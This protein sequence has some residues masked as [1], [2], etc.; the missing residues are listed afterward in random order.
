M[1]PFN[2]HLPL[3]M[4][5]VVSMIAY[6]SLFP[7]A[8]HTRSDSVGPFMT[9]LGGWDKLPGRGDFVSNILLYLP[10][11]FVGAMAPAGRASLRRLALAA[12]FGAALSVGAE[13]L[14]Y[15]DAYRDTEATDVYANTLGTMLGATAGWLFGREFR[16]PFL[17]ELSANRIPA[18]L[19]AAWLGYRLY[20]YVPTINLHK[21]WD[22]LK[23]IVL[24]PELTVLG[25]LRQTAIWLCIRALSDAIAGRRGARFYWLFAGATF[26][27]SILILFTWITAAQIAGIALAFVSWRMMGRRR[28]AVAAGLLGAYIVLYRLEPFRFDPYA[29]H[30]SWLP[31]LSFMQGSINTD[32]QA[33]CEKFFLYGGLIW[34]LGRA[35]VGIRLATLSTAMLLLATSGLEAIIPG[36]SAEVTDALLALAA[37]WIV[38][39]E[40]PKLEPA[41]EPEK[42]TVTGQFLPVEPLAEPVP[43]YE[44]AAE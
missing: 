20:P 16:M 26:V 22:A 40:R 25:L 38:G 29:E 43:A 35:G 1:K 4:V 19:L 5:A 15:Y 7:F 13:C 17:R 6:G 12:A 31:F 42:V 41:A 14:Q 8:F 3:A 23:P 30:F 2:V 10:L 39:L 18:L 24:Y 27:A 37:G 44:N 21:Y 33:F 36:R 34:L 9:L 11:G 28:A 32:V